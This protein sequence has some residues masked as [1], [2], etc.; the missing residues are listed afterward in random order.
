M[1]QRTTGRWRKT[2]DDFHHLYSSTN[3]ITMVTSRRMKWARHV[4]CVGRCTNNWLE[5]VKGDLGIDWA[6]L[7]IWAFMNKVKNR[8]VL[9][10][11][12]NCLAL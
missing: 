7:L 10:V 5:Q 4:A 3:I 1:R 2:N 6:V 9:Y 11:S 8:R 12:E